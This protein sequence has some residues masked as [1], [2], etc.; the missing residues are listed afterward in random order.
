[1]VSASSEWLAGRLVIEIGGRIS[2]G[3]CG[4]LL[5]QAGATVVFVE[6]RGGAD[7]SGK[8]SDRALFSAGKCSL[9][10][11]PGDP[12]DEAALA[13]LL[14]R[15]DIVLTSS[16][17]DCA[18]AALPIEFPRS[19]T[20][21]N[22][23]ALGA[24]SGEVG[25]TEVDVQALSGVAHTSG[26]PDG[27]P[28]ALRMPILEYSAGTYGS[29]ACVAALASMRD[30][31]KPQ[32]IEVSLFA[33]AIHALAS[34]LP[35]VF[36][37]EDPGR[38]GNGHPITAP[39]NAYPSSDGWL[40]FCSASDAH[41]TRFCQAFGR[42]ELAQDTRFRRVADRVRN[43]AAVDA[44]VAECTRGY[45]TK[46]C[47]CLFNHAGLAIGEIVSIDRLTEEVNVRHR[48]S[49]AASVVPGTAERVPVPRSILATRIA[50]STWV[51]HIPPVDGDRERLRETRFRPLADD[52]PSRPRA[53]RRED[54]EYL[55]LRG[56]RVVEIG[57]FTTA[58]LAAR[59]LAMYGAEIAKIEPPSGDAA[60]EWAPMIDGVSCF[61]SMSNSGKTCYHVDLKTPD[62]LSKLEDLLRR[63]DVLV[64]NMKPGSLAALGLDVTRLMEINPSLI[65]CPISGF[66]SDSAYANRPAFDTVVQAM[67]G[68]M[69]ANAIGGIPLK[70][71]V[72][73]CDFM[74]GEV[75]LFAI[76][77]ALYHR[78]DSGAG[79][80]L[81]LSMQEIAIWMTASLWKKGGFSVP[82]G[83]MVQCCDGYVLAGTEEVP[84]PAASGTV[85]RAEAVAICRQA[86]VHC[87]PV[88][89]VAEAL[90]DAPPA[91]AG[92]LVR[93]HRASTGSEIPILASPVSISPM[94]L[95][96][97][98]PPDR[99]CAI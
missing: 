19:A 4:S 38:F 51:P 58:P 57:Q 20:I 22:F 11:K 98:L 66:G 33:C 90:H 92:L 40:V 1:M 91:Q 44:I 18:I 3:V 56:V 60:R 59:H 89:T 53:A 9:A 88:R 35:S 94:A 97:G 31:G 69:D 32:R 70:S 76:S 87:V 26:F 28:C 13:D 61:F 64:E 74:G 73:V 6:T 83:R 82:V 48:R 43:R 95:R 36:Q 8:F 10:V 37:G 14:R 63:S 54:G 84:A 47:V 16:D 78:R 55:P 77:A 25:L 12:A 5:A 62:G 21:C 29:A 96:P 81:D 85:S 72:S 50:P 24:E 42:P 17:W 68:I 75:A 27:P 41:W 39:W 86:G 99:P 46:T 15:A 45:D 34:F 65:Y 30:V 79:A 80:V 23:T 7:R 93:M 71:S 52:G 49:I 67:S 2:V